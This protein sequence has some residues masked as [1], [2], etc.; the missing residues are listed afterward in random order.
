[1]F[2]NADALAT[3]CSQTYSNKYRFRGLAVGTTL[4][5]DTLNS[6]EENRIF[7]AKGGT[8]QSW[9]A[10]EGIRKILGS[11]SKEQCGITKESDT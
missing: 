7:P 4:R 3:T 10:R 5:Q 6:R 2:R 11:K 1:M 9:S 8:E